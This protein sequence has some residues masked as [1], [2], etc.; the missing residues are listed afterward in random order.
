[1]QFDKKRS[2]LLKNEIRK[3]LFILKQTRSKPILKIEK[4]KFVFT[5]NKYNV[6]YVEK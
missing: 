6:K 3:K 1:M 2:M 5:L 4:I